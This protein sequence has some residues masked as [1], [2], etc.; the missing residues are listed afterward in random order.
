MGQPIPNDST[1]GGRR[2]R[3][4]NISVTSRLRVAS[5][6]FLVL[7]CLSLD[8]DSTYNRR[9]LDTTVTAGLH[10]LSQAFSY[11]LRGEDVFEY[12]RFA[13]R[14]RRKERGV[15]KRR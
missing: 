7:D 8:N 9:Y 4:I 1:N 11:I 14:Q 3:F 15:D 12:E 10:H 13:E 2:F 5:I 6:K